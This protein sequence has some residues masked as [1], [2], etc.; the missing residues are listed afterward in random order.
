MLTKQAM[1]QASC[2]EEA[3]ITSVGWLGCD[4]EDVHRLTLEAFQQGFSHFKM[5]AGV[6]VKSGLRRRKVSSP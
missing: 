5:K 1:V 4:D 2:K 6:N 3:N